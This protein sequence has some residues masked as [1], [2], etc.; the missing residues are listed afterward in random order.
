[1]KV[2]EIFGRNII[3]QNFDK[4]YHSVLSSQSC[5]LLYLDVASRVSERR[6]A[7]SLFINVLHITKISLI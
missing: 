3:Y 7:P 5:N 6:K 2:Y 1:M 4:F